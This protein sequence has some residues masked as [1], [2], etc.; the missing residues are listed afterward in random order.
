[1]HRRDFLTHPQ[2]V[3]AALTARG[4]AP[5]PLALTSLKDPVVTAELAALIAS[6]KPALI[7]TTTAFSPLR[8]RAIR[9][10]RRVG[11]SAACRGV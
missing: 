8:A 3:A 11:S 6:R 5:L 9:S 2:E 1:M 7:V 10:P 4:L